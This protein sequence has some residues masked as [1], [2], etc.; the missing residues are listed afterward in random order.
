MRA[1]T[2]QN[3]A[4]R[5]MF[6][7]S[8]GLL[9]KVRQARAN[10]HRCGLLRYLDIQRRKFAFRE[11]WFLAIREKPSGKFWEN[12]KAFNVIVPPQGRCYADP[13]LVKKDGTNYLFFEE[14]DLESNKATIAC[15]VIDR[16]GAHSRPETALERDYHLS[17]PSIFEW[18][19][20]MYMIPETS[21]NRTIEL[22][23]ATEF[24]LRWQLVKVLM[25]DV[26][27]ADTT[28]YFHCG[29]Y[30]MFTTIAAPD[31][32]PNETLFLFFA[33]SPLG[34]WHAHPKN[35]IISDISRA[36][37]AGALFVSNGDLLRPSQDCS[38]DY[39]Q[40]MWLNR[41]TV[42][43]EFEYDEVSTTRINPGFLQGDI[44][45]HTLSQNE[46]WEVR[47]GFWWVGRWRGPNRD[48]PSSRSE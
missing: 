18:H 20:D 33:D 6:Q 40:A 24:P 25:T 36:R 37:P 30:W 46:D 7:G 15:T 21:R 28:L 8:D 26:N 16:F 43:S 22:Y 9:R 10:I 32:E 35:P 14:Y 12:R 1:M 11:C 27:A 45:T 41:I 13:C 17:Y 44:R 48:D 23:R 38:S 29:R 42:L 3:Q 19:D 34:P 5:N 4:M 39:G 47:D 2:L 31:S